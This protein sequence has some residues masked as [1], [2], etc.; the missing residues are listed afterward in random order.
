M[1]NMCCTK[2]YIVQNNV[3]GSDGV[4]DGSMPYAAWKCTSDLLG[5]STGMFGSLCQ[6]IHFLSVAFMKNLCS[7]RNYTC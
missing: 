5:P 4:A 7:C 2:V 1:L 3:I 6:D